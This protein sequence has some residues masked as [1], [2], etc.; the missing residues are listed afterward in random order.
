MDYTRILIGVASLAGMSVVFA[1]ILGVASRVFAVET[2]ERIPSIVA[3]LPG[4]NCGGCGFAGCADYATNVVLHGAACNR[5]PVGGAPVAAKVSEIM[6]VACDMAEPQV[7]VVHCDGTCQNTEKKYEYAGLA[8]CNAVMTLGGGDKSCIYSCIGLGSCVKACQ[9]DAIHVIDGTAV[10]DREKCT[11][12]AACVRACPKHIISLKPV[13]GVVNVICSSEDKGPVV[14]DICKVGCI[15]CG[16]CAKNCPVEAITMADNLA[17]IDPDK[18]IKCGI[19][20][21]KCPR[22]IIHKLGE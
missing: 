5:C 13:S 19:C 14:R 20:I 6:G 7:A 22:K 11:A 4:A 8:D 12:C 10:V 17:H 18:C 16:I 1:I 3:V 21:E 15:G 2:D 9:F